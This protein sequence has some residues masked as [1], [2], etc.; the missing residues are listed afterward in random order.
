[1]AHAP[2]D[3]AAAEYQAIALLRSARVATLATAIAGQ[4]FASLVTP[5]T[6]PDRS[7]LLLLSDLSEHTRHLAAEARCSLLVSGPAV[8]ANP[9]TAPRLTVTGT[10]S[11]CADPRLKAR[12]LA[13][14]PYA[15]GYAEFADFSLW[16]VTL[17][18]GL[19]VGGFARATRLR[20]T[21]LTA[22]PTAVAA[23]DV[24]AE[25]I[26]THCNDDHPDALAAIADAPGAW[27]MVGV[28]VDGCDLAQGET[29]RR[30]AWAAPVADAEGVRAE[31]IRLA[32]RR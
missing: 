31:L 25:M 22:D 16:C 5:A 7:V 20:K 27:R 12:W 19:L 10:A 14:H 17:G 4:P 24:T 29:V 32:R 11:R 9:Q 13:I 23:I 15:S 8:T 3:P 26:M 1:M 21:V 6:A 2:D 28:D 30:I 18:G